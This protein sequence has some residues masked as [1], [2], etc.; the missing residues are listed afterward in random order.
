M[1]PILSAP[2]PTTFIREAPELPCIDYSL[3]LL[4]DTLDVTNVL[5][6]FAAAL[7]ESRILLI[8]SQYTVLAV[9][10]EALRTILSPLKWPHVYIPVI[11]GRMLDYL[12]CPTPF[13]FGVQKDLLDANLLS[14]HSISAI[15][16]TIML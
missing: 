1:A 11:P 13:I 14:T 15:Y 2:I 6:L 16:L 3:A 12:H 10:A 7:L 5:T 9:V 8:S 4:F